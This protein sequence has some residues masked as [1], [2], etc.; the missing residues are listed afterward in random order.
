MMPWFPVIEGESVSEGI[1]LGE[2]IGRTVMVVRGDV[3]LM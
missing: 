1:A 2:S 3:T